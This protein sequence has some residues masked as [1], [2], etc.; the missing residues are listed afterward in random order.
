[1]ANTSANLDQ[2]KIRRAREILGTRG[3]TDT[4]DR[5]LDSVLA[6]F[7]RAQL[8]RHLDAKTPQ[9]LEELETARDGAWH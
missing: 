6:Q 7:A 4:L 9:E 3:I 1:M 5:A 8:V 2:D